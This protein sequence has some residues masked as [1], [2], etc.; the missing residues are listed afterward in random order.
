MLQKRAVSSAS[1]PPVSRNAL[2]TDSLRTCNKNSTAKVKE[3]TN[4]DTYM[5]TCAAK[6]TLIFENEVRFRCSNFNFGRRE[7]PTLSARSRM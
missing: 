2:E 1:G 3:N 4:Y 6:S 5:C 7:I